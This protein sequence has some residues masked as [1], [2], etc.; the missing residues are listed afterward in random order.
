[1]DFF[2]TG[3]QLDVIQLQIMILSHK[4]KNSCMPAKKNKMQA[5]VKRK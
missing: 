2:L 1:M 4:E 3:K 5:V